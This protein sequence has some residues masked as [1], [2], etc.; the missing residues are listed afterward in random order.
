VATGGVSGRVAAARVA[1]RQRHDRQRAQLNPLRLAVLVVVGALALLVTP[2]PGLH[3]RGLAITVSLLVYVGSMLMAPPYREGRSGTVVQFV[4]LFVIGAAGIALAALQPQPASALPA[5][6]AVLMAG[7]RLRPWTAAIVE[8]PVTAGLAV[9]TYGNSNAQTVAGTVLLCLVLAVDGALVRQS[10]LSRDCTEVLMAEL[11]DARDDQARAAAVAERSRIAREL[12]DV[13]AHSLAALSIQLEGARKLAANDGASAALRSVIDRSAALAKQGTVEARDAVG[14]L[15]DDDLTTFERLPELVE[16][17]R[18][19][20]GVQVSLV[21]EGTSRALPA[22]VGLTLYRVVGEALTNVSR[23]APGAA[24]TVLVQWAPGEVHLSV[25]DEGG[26]PDA[27]P[28][29]PGGGWGLVGMRE[30]VTRTGGR[31]VVGPRGAGWSVDVRV[32]A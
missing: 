29:P 23:H 24:T 7:I 19:D 31:F 10:R 3:G 2:G 8:V 17:Y 12:H 6:A 30:R 32:P 9:V 28:E 20:L 16:H 26:P 5:S 21:V 11:E 22:E 4:D 15:R 1:A 25:V 27:R 13:L 18:R 14:A